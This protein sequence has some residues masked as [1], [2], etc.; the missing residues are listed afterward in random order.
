[1]PESLG[2]YMLSQC[3]DNED[4]INIILGQRDGGILM[5]EIHP[6]Q[7]WLTQHH[8]L[9]NIVI[10]QNPLTRKLILAG[11][12]GINEELIYTDFLILYVHRT[13]WNQ[14]KQALANKE[15]IKLKQLLGDN[16]DK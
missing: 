16:K 6:E 10:Y 14:M 4:P 7:L 9:P 2:L 15:E 1:M 5:N 13:K 12:M 8:L 11:D 3:E